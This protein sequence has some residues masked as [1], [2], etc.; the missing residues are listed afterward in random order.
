MKAK[1]NI[2]II[3]LLFHLV[4][5]VG[6]I[7]CAQEKKTKAE[8]RFIHP[9]SKYIAVSGGWAFTASHIND[10]QRFLDNGPIM[11]NDGL[12]PNI[13][14]EQGIQNDFFAEMGYSF[15]PQ[16]LSIKQT[17]GESSGSST[18]IL[19]D[20][21]DLQIGGGYRLI[22]KNNFHLCNFHGG[23]FLGYTMN[24]VGS[25]SWGVYTVND[26]ETHKKYKFVYHIDDYS[27]FAIGPYLGI[28][29]ELRL[30]DDVRFFFKYTQRFGLVSQASGRIALSSEEF[31][32]NHD[33]FFNLRGGGAYLAF[34]FKVLLFKK[35]LS[36][37][38]KE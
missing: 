12:F 9:K 17:L 31:P 2:L 7:V 4:I 25:S 35:K 33:A 11:Q 29:K 24:H 26:I 5:I 3:L 30:S 14:Y 19:H 15:I 32:L 36:Q 1:F 38:D 18:F 23:L 20:N 10:P 8:K 27:K 34:G 13:M 16:G 21:H 22:L 6:S 37:L 28:S